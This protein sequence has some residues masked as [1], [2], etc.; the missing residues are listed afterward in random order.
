MPR[1]QRATGKADDSRPAEEHE[2]SD[3]AVEIPTKCAADFVSD[4]LSN[5][6]EEN[7][8]LRLALADVGDE[9]TRLLLAAEKR[10]QENGLTRSVALSPSQ[11]GPAMPGDLYGQCV[12]QWVKLATGGNKH[13]AA[14][15]RHRIAEMV[16]EMEAEGAGTKS[17]R[18]LIEQV[19]IQ[20][21][22]VHFYERLQASTSEASAEVAE[23]KSRKAELALRKYI[24]A[25]ES[26]AK[27]RTIPIRARTLVMQQTV[28]PSEAPKPCID[29]ASTP[30]GSN[31]LLS[32]S[33]GSVEGLIPAI[34]CIDASSVQQLEIGTRDRGRTNRSTR[35]ARSIDAGG[36][37][38]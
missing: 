12:E 4:I 24:K 35:A 29:V 8:V 16:R 15:L 5:V 10:N 25:I 2:D 28:L 20:W 31:L 30:V 19:A 21:V 22:Q 9:E 32:P 26:L 18:L 7:A 1:E 3:G 23:Y 13:E 33:I 36:K 6:A 11:S 34:A 14:G 38:L 37:S 17:E 27:I